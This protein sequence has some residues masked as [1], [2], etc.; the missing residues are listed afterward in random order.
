LCGVVR[1]QLTLLQGG[2]VS[3]LLAGGSPAAWKSYLDK[4]S[5][6]NRELL[7]AA[8]PEVRASVQTEAATTAA[9][10]DA[11]AGAGYDVSKVGTARVLQL[12]DTPQRKEADAVFAVYLK[13]HCG[14]DLTKV[15]G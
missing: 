7:D 5:A 1:Q 13:A 14:V 8:P 9:M 10:K 12:M 4:V 15:G 3:G 2:E 6:M 11:L